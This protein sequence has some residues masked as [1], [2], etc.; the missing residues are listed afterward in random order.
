MFKPKIFDT[1]KN[2]NRQQ[3]G[4]DVMAGLIVGIVALPLPLPLPLLPAYRRKKVYI[5]PLL[6]DLLFRQWVAAV[7]KLV[8]PP[9]H[10]L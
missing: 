9:V 8:A 4:K 1:L 2:Y 3:F 5:Q 6:Q 7:Y 10:L